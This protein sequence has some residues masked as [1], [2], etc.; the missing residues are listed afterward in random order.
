MI[1]FA[2]GSVDPDELEDIKSNPANPVVSTDAV[3][4]AGIS[5][6]GQESIPKASYDQIQ[7]DELTMK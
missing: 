5:S 1:V 2:F 6:A 3:D 7:N 4:S